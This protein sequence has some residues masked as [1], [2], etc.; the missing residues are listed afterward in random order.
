MQVRYELNFSKLQNT[1]FSYN[2]FMNVFHHFSKLSSIS[3]EDLQKYMNDFTNARLLKKYV[4]SDKI[5]NI[6]TEHDINIRITKSEILVTSDKIFGFNFSS[7]RYI[8]F[9][10][11]ENK[12]IIGNDNKWDA[13]V[14]TILDKPYT[15]KCVYTNANINKYLHYIEYK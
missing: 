11:N 10:N 1:N 13:K 6:L 2:D 12:I 5:R 8:D 3:F 15:I 4:I 14:Y 7:R 9:T